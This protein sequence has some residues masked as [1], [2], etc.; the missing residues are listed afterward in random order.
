M[1][2]PEEAEDAVRRQKTR[3]HPPPPPTSFGFGPPPPTT[4]FG[5]GPTP[6]LPTYGY[7]RTEPAPVVVV[8]QQRKAV[9]TSYIFRF[10]FWLSFMAFVVADAAICGV[11]LADAESNR[12]L[13]S[14]LAKL[15]AKSI[16]VGGGLLVG[17]FLWLIACSPF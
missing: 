8:D 16:V 4:D 15:A 1:L 17:G 10:L 5:F 12:H 9:P 14:P 13:T 3:P 11:L 6:T 7:G 2:T